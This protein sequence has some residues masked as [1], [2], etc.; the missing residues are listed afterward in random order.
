MN[1]IRNQELIKTSNIKQTQT[2]ETLQLI[3]NVCNTFIIKLNEFV[4]DYQNYVDE[5]IKSTL[6]SYQYKITTLINNI[7]DKS[8]TF[9]VFKNI[10]VELNSLDSFL[11]QN[12]LDYSN[13]I[14]D[15][16]NSI[17]K[18][19]HE[20]KQL[21][22]TYDIEK[23]NLERKLI[24]E[25][26]INKVETNRII[27][28]H[29]K[30][31][32]ENKNILNEYQKEHIELSNRKYELELELEN[33]KYENEQYKEIAKIHRDNI[34][35]QI[36]DNKKRKAQTLQY[37]ES[38]KRKLTLIEEEIE[39]LQS[40]L[41]QYK[42][43]RYNISINYHSSLFE[44]SYLLKFILNMDSFE[45]NI[46]TNNILTQL[47]EYFNNE[48]YAV[49]FNTIISTLSFPLLLNDGDERLIGNIKEGLDSFINSINNQL[50]LDT[51]TNI[52]NN[53]DGLMQ[54][55][56]N[57]TNYYLNFIQ[58]KLD[59]YSKNYLETELDKLSKKR[60]RQELK[61][62]KL[63]SQ[64]RKLKKILN[65]NISNSIPVKDNFLI[66]KRNE[67][68]DLNKLRKITNYKLNNVNAKLQ[69]IDNKIEHLSKLIYNNEYS[70]PLKED[71]IR[72]NTRL[73]KINNRVNKSLR[74]LDKG[75]I[76]D[77]ENVQTMK[78]N[79][80]NKL[81]KLQILEKGYNTDFISTLNNVI[82]I[83][84]KYS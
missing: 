56:N 6:Y 30:C 42:E 73:N 63:Q 38:A 52:K 27:N 19:T 28:K 84:Q 40:F 70:E 75:Y 49:V 8:L 57:D 53:L 34:I 16:K 9:N 1:F 66:N 77:V 29:S 58:S 3:Y 4:G 74:N 31:I 44:I 36:S 5:T 68:S 39:E 12:K 64:E 61:L 22:K 78:Y 69:Y 51:S 17:I 21:K 43:H 2:Q 50:K 65:S 60:K 46:T 47:N 13:N 23:G 11:Q 54:L 37:K 24:K 20:L 32:T 26:E 80:E 18:T 76:T 72:S 14:I 10:L 48:N 25:Q 67:L 82:S 79:L 35:Q 83:I 33:I 62:R 55:Y 15:I 7:D 41:Q 59:S 45:Y 71:M 81:S